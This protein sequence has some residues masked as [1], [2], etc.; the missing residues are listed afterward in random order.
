MKWMTVNPIVLILI[1]VL[2]PTMY[3]FIRGAYLQVFLAAFCAAILCVTGNFKRLLLFSCIY[4]AMYAGSVVCLSVPQLRVMVGFLVIMLQFI[5]FLALASVVVGSYSSSELLSALEGMRIPRVIVVATTI[6]FK[7]VPTFRRE[8]GYITESMRLRGIS[9]TWR[10]PIASF[11]YF[12]V[13]Q[14]F[15][16]AALAEE[17]TAAG[18]V[19]GINAPMRRSS[20]YELSFR[21]TDAL[22]LAVFATGIIGGF[23]WKI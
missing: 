12:V 19:K 7:Y 9:F 2:A 11:R 20:Y 23:L 17:V 22:I 6:T 5:P 1:N 3:I 16:C 18:L 8:F 15:R 4:A 10:K 13:P 21:W 14:L